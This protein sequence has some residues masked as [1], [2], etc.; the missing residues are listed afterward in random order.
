MSKKTL[1]NETQVRK[2]MKLASLEPL[3]A[4]FIS[5][6]MAESHGRGR[7]E[8]DAG[9]GHHDNNTRLEEEAD[10]ESLEDYAA[11]DLERG[12]PD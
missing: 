3:T 11:G 6:E 5:E 2:F 8:G 4:R 7:G 10:A 12:H 9:Y 1:L